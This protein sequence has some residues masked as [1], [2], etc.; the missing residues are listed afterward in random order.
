MN[1]ILV[2][3]KIY[4]TPE[5]K[6]K[7]NFYKIHFFIS[8]ILIIVLACVYVYAEYDRNRNE[9]I[10][11][12][13]LSGISDDNTT[14]EDQVLVAYLDGEPETDTNQNVQQEESISNSSQAQGQEQSHVVTTADGSEYATVATVEIPSLNLSYPVLAETSDTLLKVAPCKFWGPNPNEVGNFCI[15][16]HN[17]R[18]KKFFSKVPNLAIGDIVQL[19]D[20][21]GRTLT[22]KIYDKYT[23]DPTDVRCTSQLTNGKKEV[24]LITCTNDSQQRVILK[25]T[26]V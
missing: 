8:V 6:R 17:Y 23:V 12:E 25:A 15:V 7:K 1:Q 11:Q 19:T 21:S 9:A 20:L 24:T 26:Q 4:V 13:V 14:V 10:S 5:L 22:Y 3:K 18:N 16:G 2:T